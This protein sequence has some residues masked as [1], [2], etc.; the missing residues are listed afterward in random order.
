MGDALHSHRRWFRF[1]LRTM[2]VLVTACAL[3]LGW[4]HMLVQSRLTARRAIVDEGG[5][6][7]V[8]DNGNLSPIDN[9]NTGFFPMF[10]D[11]PAAEKLP[12]LRRWLGDASVLE[13]ELNSKR[14]SKQ[15]VAEIQRLFPEATVS[16]VVPFDW[17]VHEESA[18]S[19]P[20]AELIPTN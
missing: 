11:V 5:R 20:T 3:W 6:I 16:E 17:R 14:T 19:F 13:V 4:N 18:A 9:G 1:S 12:R 10:A 7:W 2:F 15:T 8:V